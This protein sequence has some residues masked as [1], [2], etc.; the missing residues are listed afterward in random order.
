MSIVTRATKGSMLTHV[1]LDANFNELNAGLAARYTKT[2]AD[3]RIEQ[4]IGTAPANLDTLGE[5]AA[6]LAADESAVAG[7]ITTLAN[8]ADLAYVNQ[9]KVKNITLSGD[10][11]GTGIADSNGN[12]SISAVVMGDTVVNKGNMS[13]NV[14]INYGEGNY[15]HGVVVGATTIGAPSAVPDSTKAYGLTLEITNGGTNVTWPGNITWV[16]GSAPSLKASGINII[17][18]IT[19][20]GGS[21]WLGS[22]T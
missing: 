1:E 11:T 21:T 12:V 3:A 19:R 15:I 7:I 14:A 20:N 13:G 5:I 8:K 10:V 16:S 2:E 18:L 4:I 9:V 17:T 6:Q 22:S